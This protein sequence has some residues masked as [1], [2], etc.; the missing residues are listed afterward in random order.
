MPLEN[1]ALYAYLRKLS[2]AYSGRIAELRE[3]A[4]NWLGYIPETFPHYTR[5]TVEHSDEIILQMSKM[6]FHDNDPSRPRLPLSP[7]EAYI[8]LAAA[9]LHDSGMVVP[10]AEKA[11][12][13]E[14]D[15][16]KHWI[17][18]GGGAKRWEAIEEFRAGTS[19]AEQVIRDFLADR[20]TR[21]LIAEFVR[22][23]H[24]LR[25]ANVIEEHH[26]AL[27][28]FDFGDAILRRMI[29]NVCVGHGLRSYELEDR[30]R[31]PD[32]CD[33]RGDPANVRFLAILLRLGDLLDL[34]SDRAC[35]LLLNAASPLP[36]DSL[37]HWSRHQ[38]IRS[39]LTAPERISLLAECE[40]QEEHRLLRDWCQW[41]V[42][43]VSD[44]RTLMA[45]CERHREWQP[46]IAV[47]DG[48]Q[49]T[50]EI[51]AA[52]DATYVAAD[53][54]FELDP[55]AVF[56][57]L[58][59]DVYESPLSYVRELIQNALDATRCQL[60]LDLIAEGGDAPEDL[61][62]V[63]E[64]RRQRYPVRVILR[65]QEIA[66]PMSGEMETRQVLT[67]E[68]Q[69]IGMDRDVIQRYL[70]QVGRSYYVSDEFRRSYTFVPT[71]HFGVGFLSVFAVSDFVTVESHKPTSAANDGPLRLTL[72]GPKSYLLIDR[73][74][75]P[76]SGTRVEVVLREPIQP[77][78]LTEAISGW[79]RRVEFPVIVND[80]SEETVVEAECPE[81]FT[82]DDT[83]DVTEEG[84]KFS[85]L[86]YPFRE[87]GERGEVYIFSRTATDGESWVARDWSL[88]SYPSMHPGATPP[89]FP[90]D[91]E[92][93]N[94]ITVGV[95]HEF[96]R[97]RAFAVRVDIRGRAVQP[98][99]ARSSW[100]Y[101]GHPPMTEIIPS[102]A[103]VLE[104]ALGRHLETTERARGDRSWLYKQRLINCFPLGAFWRNTPGTISVVTRRGNQLASLTDVD[105]HVMIT[106]VISP[107]ARSP[108]AS[109]ERS[110]VPPRV[111][112]DGNVYLTGE[113]V[114]SLSHEHRRSIF[115]KRIAENAR[116][117]D[118]NLAVDWR[119]GD[120]SGG[121]TI[122]PRKVPLLALPTIEVIGIE[123]HKTVDDIY[124]SELL[125]TQ[126][127]FVQ[128]L[129]RAVGACTNGQH[130]LGNPQ[131][132]Q[133]ES[134]VEDA[135]RYPAT[136]MQALRR[137][138]A[139]WR[140]IPDL[141][142]DFYPPNIEI[143]QH[144]FRLR[145]TE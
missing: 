49:P 86:A 59:H 87:I 48:A 140:K 68:D 96:G 93:V 66:S 98:T 94:G 103:R 91:L 110:R 50:I 71:S 73:G 82:H 141:P 133:L 8:L 88:H 85:V 12:I 74:E 78:I 102:A 6:L 55:E 111:P 18:E 136:R 130:G 33:I 75:R 25:A 135:V 17:T 36:P 9:Y 105:S 143:T 144:S 13:I 119:R 20:Q 122:G 81:D 123:I 4:Q 95:G 52:D 42:N 54:T 64:E 19:P 112:D 120:Q 32:W 56:E 106:T 15:Q 30:D 138:V 137:Y 53:W 117:M 108:D 39:R 2:D 46:P 16:W 11:Q 142:D 34:S 26:V 114:D 99:L 107:S 128:W 104:E 116:W 100:R 35:P 44:A 131:R 115:I 101:A 84:A 22:R 76:Q 7:V 1:A 90:N 57:R 23:N 134:L 113:V 10:D 124:P 89:P 65:T 24:H 126:H 77:G 129:L 27:A 118:G 3:V 58:I 109:R 61:T 83:P 62:D 60:Y 31:F 139:A 43:E 79:C 97:D 51:R 14:S 125:N 28:G 38:R 80:L 69:G 63:E 145:S 72:T 41:I 45:R 37:P 40:N 92:C 127:P 132:Q 121:V 29:A 47:M 21:F 70:L 67:V 5:H